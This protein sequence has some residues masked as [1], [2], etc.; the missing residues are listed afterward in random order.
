M[1]NSHQSI[2]TDLGRVHGGADAVFAAMASRG[3]R[4]EAAIGRLWREANAAQRVRLLVMA[5]PELRRFMPVAHYGGLADHLA[6]SKCGQAVQE[7]SLL[8]A[9]CAVFAGRASTALGR[10]L[11]WWVDALYDLAYD[12]LARAALPGLSVRS[13]DVTA[14]QP[15]VEALQR[16]VLARAKQ[17]LPHLTAEQQ[18]ALT[19]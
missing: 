8:D 17:L 6:T 7:A 11:Q 15:G 3:D 16:E 13:S 14:A 4:F 2:A 10:N 12:D 18:E 9:V 19:C 5:E 1:R